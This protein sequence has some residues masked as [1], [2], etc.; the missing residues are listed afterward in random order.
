[1]ETPEVPGS[2]S[3]LAAPG[4]VEKKESKSLQIFPTQFKVMLVGDSGVGKTALM[5]RVC[6][7]KFISKF[8]STIGVDFMTSSWEVDNYIVR[9]Q[10]WDTAG[11]ERFRTITATYYQKSHSIFLV[12]DVTCNQ[13]FENLSTWLQ[14]INAI[15]GTIPKILIGNKTDVSTRREVQREKAEKFAKKHNMLFFETS[16][17]TNSEVDT[18]FLSMARLVLANQE[19]YEQYDRRSTRSIQ[20]HDEVD[21]KQK[22][23]GVIKKLTFLKCAC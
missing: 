4:H 23:A 2:P 3:N 21:T 17:K 16:A 15:R 20:L 7:K 5:R 11:Q 10:L 1:M 22:S 19:L 6:E 18:A 8:E 9:L 12:Y 14:D 13:S